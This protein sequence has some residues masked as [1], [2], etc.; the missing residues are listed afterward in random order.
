VKSRRTP[1][2]DVL[3]KLGDRGTSSPV[4]GKLVNL[5]LSGDFTGDQKPKETFGKGFRSTGGLGEE[6]LAFRDSLATET[7]T[8]LSIQNGA[9]PDE[10]WKTTHTTIELVNQDRAKG[11]LAVG[12]TDSLHIFDFAWDKL[13][14]TLLKGNRLRGS[15]G[16]AS[17]REG[18]AKD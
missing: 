5:L 18:G 15:G 3:D 1:V 9:V 8:L 17:M 13:S 4:F 12:S 16:E 14:K 10:S 2:Q 7:N 6:V 11:L